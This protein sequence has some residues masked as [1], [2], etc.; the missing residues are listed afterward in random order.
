MKL[1]Y[2]FLFGAVVAFSS[3]S[4]AYRSAQTPDDVYYSP[5]PVQGESVAN[6]SD[7][8]RDSYYYQDEEESQIR[9]GIQDPAYR[10]PLTVGLGYGMGYNPYAYNSLYNPYY[11][12]YNPLSYMSFYNPYMPMSYGGFGYGWGSFY[13]PYNSFNSPFYSPYYGG[14]YYGHSYY[15]GNLYY[16]G[17]IGTTNSSSPR[18]FNLNPY[19]NG[20]SVRPGNTG[21]VSPS[22]SPAPIRRTTG[23]GNVIR[24][25]IEPSRERNTYVNPNNNGERNNNNNNNY[26]QPPQ[27]TFNTPQVNSS[28]SMGSPSS[29]PSSSGG[30]APVRSF[31]R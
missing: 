25:V 15:P 7:Q 28:P 4:T 1:K 6:M 29:A 12:G 17:N 10:T 21:V 11:G 30:S 31:G 23:V 14:S 26:N 18:T 24:R 2:I 22:N 20:N 8:G 9:Q 3:C 13:D 5:A 27:R 19:T 16:P